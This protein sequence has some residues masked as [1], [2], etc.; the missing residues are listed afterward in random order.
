[1]GDIRKL[2]LQTQTCPVRGD[3][4]Q[5]HAVVQ[6]I[7][8]EEPAGGFHGVARRNLRKRAN[9]S[10]FLVPSSKLKECPQKLFIIYG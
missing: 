6:W 5:H 2:I 4:P 3:E 7:E 8:V 1:M 9:S 10:K